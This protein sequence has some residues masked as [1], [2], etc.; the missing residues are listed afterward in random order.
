MK[1]PQFIACL[2]SCPVL[3]VITDHTEHSK[4][5]IILSV[6]TLP[7]PPDIRPGPRNSRWIW[8]GQK[9]QPGGCSLRIWSGSYGVSLVCNGP[10]VSSDDARE[11]LSAARALETISKRTEAMERT[12]GSATDA[13]ETVARWLEACG[14][15]EVWFRPGFRAVG[16]HSEGTWERELPGLTVSR[17]RS[18]ITPAHSARL[19]RIAAEVA[20]ENAQASA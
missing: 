14:I 17:I 1:K 4:E 16:W 18:A 5:D 19:A 20:A 6:M 10:S 12:R 7:D 8:D 13:A 15:T 11:Y 2:E 9:F 3:P